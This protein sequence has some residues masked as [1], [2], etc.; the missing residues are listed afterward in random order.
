MTRRLAA[1]AL[2]AAAL[3]SLAPAAPANAKPCELGCILKCVESTIV[4]FCPPVA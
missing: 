4:S 3:V 1:A 2:T